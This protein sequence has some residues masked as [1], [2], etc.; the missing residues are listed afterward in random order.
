MHRPS[1]S[2]R[3]LAPA[4]VSLLCGCSTPTYDWGDYDTLLYHAYQRPSGMHRLQR[5][6]EQH[7]ASLEANR[8]KVPPGMYAELGSLYMQAGDTRQARALYARERAA[9]PE[10]RLLMEV[11]ITGIDEAVPQTETDGPAGAS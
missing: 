4:L 9:W 5:A 11:L 6:L 3:L 1:G 8:K 10:S 7:I 2:L